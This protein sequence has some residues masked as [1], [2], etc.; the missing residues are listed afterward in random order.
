MAFCRPFSQTIFALPA[1]SQNF[2]ARLATV[3]PALPRSLKFPLL[4]ACRSDDFAWSMDFIDHH[5]SIPLEQLERALK[6][7]AELLV[8][9]GAAYAT[10]FRR[11]EAAVEHARKDDPL[12]RAQR[13]L[14]K[15]GAAV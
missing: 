13:L 1:A 7:A 2:E 15:T 5:H 6:V 10:T 12:R 9:H 14:Q 11:L 3:S 8:L 4:H